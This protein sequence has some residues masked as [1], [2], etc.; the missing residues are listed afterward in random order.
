MFIT[1][2]ILFCWL[3]NV[4]STEMYL[5]GSESGVTKPYHNEN[6][7]VTLLLPTETKS[8]KKYTGC[9]LIFLKSLLQYKK[10]FD[11]LVLYTSDVHPDDVALVRS[12]EGVKMQLVEKFQNDHID[13]RS[14]KPMITKFHLWNLKQ[15]KQIAYYDSDHVFMRD[16]SGIFEDCGDASFCA[17]QDTWING[18]YFNAGLLV[19][20]PNA[21]EYEMLLSKRHLANRRRFAEQDLLNTIYKNKW[22]QLDTKYNFMHASRESL[23]NYVPVC[24]H[25]KW[26]VLR[27]MGLVEDKWI[28]NK[29]INSTMVTTSFD[30][31]F[32]RV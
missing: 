27:E 20:R 15:Y 4:L 29:I 8:L 23:K 26:W 16:P 3:T 25:E 32:I 9:T 24:I 22:K 1:I 21:N 31:S 7:F 13:D 19:V 2:L 6:A 30:F 5:R 10:S 18:D 17:T 28:W 14:Y 11:V 12:V